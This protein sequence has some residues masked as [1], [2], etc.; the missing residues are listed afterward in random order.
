MFFDG[1]KEKSE[2]Q[3]Q[4]RHRS[5]TGIFENWPIL[6][7]TSGGVEA[8][9]SGSSH[10]LVFC[11]ATIGEFQGAIEFIE[12]D[13]HSE[14]LNCASFHNIV[15]SWLTIFF[16]QLLQRADVSIIFHNNMMMLQ[17][18]VCAKGNWDSRKRS[19]PNFIFL[20]MMK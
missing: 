4:Q 20:K 3:L 15:Q 16:L 1:E 7:I 11:Q 13:G 5:K 12:T 18:L 10:A 6:Q 9:R 17:S 8:D 19:V 2:K 14:S